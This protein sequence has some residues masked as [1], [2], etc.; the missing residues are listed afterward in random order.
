MKKG[1]IIVI[2]DETNI[3]KMVELALESLGFYIETFSDPLKGIERIKEFS[4]DVAF[5]DF[6]MTPMNGLQ[7]LEKIKIDSPDTTV[8]LMTAFGS[9]EN[10]VLAIKKGAYD[11]VLKPFSYDEFVHI[12]NRVFEYHRLNREV[13]SLKLQIENLSES[14]TIITCNSRMKEI[15]TDA[16]NIA[17]SDLPV[18]ILGESG[19]GKELF[20]KYIHEKSDRSDKPFI[21]VN[22]AAIPENLFES[23]LFGHAKGAFTGSVKDRIG[24]LEIADN[25]TLFLDEIAELPKQ[26][27]VKLLRFLQS[28]EYERIGENVT[29]KID[30]RIISATNKDIE[31]ALKQGELREDFY[32]R[33]NGQKYLLP[34]LR[35]R[36]DDIP[37]LINHFLQ[38]YSTGKIEFTDEITK[39]LSEYN[40][41]GNIREFETV[42][43]RV[44][45]I[46]KEGTVKTEYLPAEIRNLILDENISEL[47]SLPEIE[48]EH[49]IS[50]LNKIPSTKEASR[51][52]GISETSLW[53][54]KK[55]YG[56]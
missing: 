29:R 33:I 27:Q 44:V 28:G 6:K 38:K 46:T 47:K 15:L 54:K 20:A 11:Y 55:E 48:K 12:A 8:I 22:C 43:K 53:R 25:G 23:E 18:L 14:G 35:D 45:A 42:I 52:L 13:K 31:D 36:K 34:P 56:L 4:F 39:L 21:T 5:V 19:T 24:R 2:D 16:A 3:L 26:M 17:A 1:N 50:V 10:A 9:I 49:I 7:V 41:G 30:V 32:Y 51:I 40:W 37:L